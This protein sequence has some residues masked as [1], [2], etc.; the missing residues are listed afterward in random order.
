MHSHPELQLSGSG[1]PGFRDG[2]HCGGDPVHHFIKQITVQTSGGNHRQS[3]DEQGIEGVFGQG[4]GGL[5]GF[6]RKEV[7]NGKEEALLL[8]GHQPQP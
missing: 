2:Q 8:Y 3:P 1:L 6:I 7:S 5:G 4:P